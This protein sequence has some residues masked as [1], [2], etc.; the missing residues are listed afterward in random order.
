MK[1]FR[2]VV[3]ALAICGFTAIATSVHAAPI[4][5]VNPS[6]ETLPS[7]GLPFGCGTG[8]AYSAGDIPGWVDMGGGGVWQPG[9]AAGNF[10]Y[11]NSVPDGSRVAYTNGGYIWQ[12]IGTVQP[13]AI[14]QLLIDIGF[15]KDYIDPGNAWLQINDPGNTIVEQSSPFAAGTSAQFSGDWETYLATLSPDQSFVGHPLYVVLSSSGVQGDFD[16]VRVSDNLRVNAVPEPLTLSLF[17]A[18]L[19]GAAALRRRGKAKR[20]NSVS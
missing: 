3:T 11:L 13:G 6:F 7:G 15:R 5:V 18:G 10:T 2:H 17:G 9:P 19:A 4:P 12:Q 8:C 1:V 14:Y 20:R 16:N